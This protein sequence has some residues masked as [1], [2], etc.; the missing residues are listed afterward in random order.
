MSKAETRQNADVALVEHGAELVLPFKDNG[1]DVSEWVPFPNGWGISIQRHRGTYGASAGLFE[2]AVLDLDGNLR[3]DTP[4]TGDV[5]GW[6]SIPEV[7]DVMK[8]VSDLPPETR[9][10]ES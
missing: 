3:Y 1:Q 4:V 9:E 8:Q 2:V 7:L 10:V 5:I 6:L